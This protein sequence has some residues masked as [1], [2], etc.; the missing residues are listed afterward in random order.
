MEYTL[1]IG[2]YVTLTMCF[3]GSFFL[4]T[5]FDD[6]Q[7][8]NYFLSIKKLFPF[9]CITALLCSVLQILSLTETMEDVPLSEVSLKGILFLLQ[10]GSY[11]IL[12]TLRGVALF[13]VLFLSV[14]KP[15]SKV[16]WFACT[17][18]SGIAL[19]TMVWFGHGAA[20]EV[21]MGLLHL[22][23]DVA[24]ILTAGVW[25]GSL[26]A[27]CWI[28]FGKKESCI[29]EKVLKKFSQIGYAVVAILLTTGVVNTYFIVGDEVKDYLHPDFYMLLIYAKVLVFGM[30]LG[31]ASLNH[32]VFTPRLG[33]R[34]SDE[35]TAGRAVRHLRASVLLEYMFYLV[36][37]VLVAVV[38]VQSPTPDM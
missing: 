12:F 9:L 5:Y 38:G 14:R 36:I 15:A 25:G 35:A 3:G 4:S 11:D 31:L 30:M 33:Q 2:L 18:L 28:L 17:C 29:S 20:D 16:N 23:A 10:Q 13:S 6:I 27:F 7:E 26:L 1:R 34:L 22:I 19:M 21:S 24:H 32:F 8:S 37:M